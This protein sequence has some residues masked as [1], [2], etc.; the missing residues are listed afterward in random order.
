MGKGYNL[1]ESFLFAFARLARLGRGILR[2]AAGSFI[3]SSR[4][5]KGPR[6]P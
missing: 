4:Q 6:S 1:Q 3:Q 2:L 5:T